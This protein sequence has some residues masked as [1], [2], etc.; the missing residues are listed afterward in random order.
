ML[1]NTL[2]HRLA[3]LAFVNDEFLS[4]LTSSAYSIKHL[5]LTPGDQDVVLDAY[6]VGMRYIF[7]LYAVGAGCNLL[8]S[9]GIGNTSL[10]RGEK[11]S[12]KKALGQDVEKFSG[13]ER[14]NK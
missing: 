13:K 9:A 12:P 6:I 5:N 1:S 11:G 3:G 10:R 2:T 7:V 14:E 4:S 8:M